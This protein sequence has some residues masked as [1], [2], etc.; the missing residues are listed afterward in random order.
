LNLDH[1]TQSIPSCT[2]IHSRG[3][4]GCGGRSIHEYGCDISKV[5]LAY[6]DPPDVLIRPEGGSTVENVRFHHHDCLES[7]GLFEACTGSGTGK[8]DPSKNPGIAKDVTLANTV[9]VDSKWLFLLQ[10]LN[11]HMVN[12]VFERNSIIHTAKSAQIWDQGGMSHYDLLG[13]FF[14]SDSGMGSKVSPDVGAKD[15]VVLNNIFIEP[16]NTSQGGW[17]G[18]GFGHY[19]NIF[20]P[21]TI[22]LK[23]QAGS[24]YT[25]D[26]TE[27]KIEIADVGLTETYHLLK[28]SPAVDKATSD[29]TF[30]EDFDRRPVP[31]NSKFD[32]GA[33][34]YMENPPPPIAPGVGG[35]IG[36]G[37]G[38]GGVGGG[39][40]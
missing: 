26:A 8:E 40:G 12:V 37:G 29:T 15:V 36:G 38:I 22:S 23:A 20:A 35:T 39:G 25:L 32:L 28:T 13:M 7:V 16:Y 14:Y 34:E 30:K 6:R 27:K 10:I 2:E 9:S 1:G 17:I 19:N 5:A 31:F 21:S 18:G 11:T 33:S 3:S 4:C 24:A